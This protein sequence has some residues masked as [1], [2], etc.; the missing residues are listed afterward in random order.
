MHY[1]FKSRADADL[2]MMAPVGDHLL[3][4]V[5]KEPA[6]QGI[7]ELAAIPAAIAA[8]ERA[9]AA[10]DEAARHAMADRDDE[11]ESGGP[12]L[13]LHQRA[14]PMLEMMKRSIA[15]RSDIVWGV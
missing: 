7:I 4:I 1:V 3:R 8:L 10:E 15:E 9:I 6:A 11:E 12:R 2:L 13:G 14:W 5:G